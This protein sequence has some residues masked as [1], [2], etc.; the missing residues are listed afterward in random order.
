MKSACGM[1][2]KFKLSQARHG[3]SCERQ[4]NQNPCPFHDLI[5]TQRSGVNLAVKSEFLAHVG[6][7][8]SQKCEGP[9]EK[10]FLSF[11]R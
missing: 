4:S 11:T 6:L 1:V 7:L 9:V 10:D 2:Q 8:L 5:F 3:D